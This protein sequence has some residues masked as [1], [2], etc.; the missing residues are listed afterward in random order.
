MKKLMVIILLCSLFF[1][2]CFA[3]TEETT[4]SYSEGDDLVIEV[5]WADY[6]YILKMPNDIHYFKIYYKAMGREHLIYDSAQQKDIDGFDDYR[7]ISQFY[8]KDANSDGVEE[9]YLFFEDSF[10]EPYEMVLTYPSFIKNT[11]RFL[12]ASYFGYGDAIFEY[13]DID[14]NGSMDLITPHPGGGGMVSVWNGLDL[15]NAYNPELQTYVFSYPLTRKKYENQNSALN[16]QLQ[17]HLS[18]EGWEKL[19]ESYADLGETQRCKEMIEVSKS[20]EELNVH[21]DWQGPYDSYFEY[22][23]ARAEYYQEIWREMESVDASTVLS[24]ALV[25][26]DFELSNGLYADMPYTEF[27]DVMSYAGTLEFPANGSGFSDPLA[28]VELEGLV[29]S[30]VWPSPNASD[31]VLF[32][33]VIED[34]AILTK[35]GA[36][37][38][39]PTEELTGLYGDPISQ[40]EWGLEY[41][42][43]Q[44]TLLFELAGDKVSR[45]RMLVNP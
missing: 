20:L 15:V 6:S 8:V 14:E 17:A 27:C 34:P 29:V 16:R 2:G 19:L 37:I 3:N 23:V 9:F 38:G 30:F 45:F 11:N 31:P 24:G 33:Y 18:P 32:G 42:W 26:V 21:P 22:I 41:R 10:E 13:R 40:S 5:P 25:E 36:G 35:R 7:F 43:N 12:K 1:F 44:Y 4:Y 28:S 39:M